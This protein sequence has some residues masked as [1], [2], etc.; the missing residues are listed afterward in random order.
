M[1]AAFKLILVKSYFDANDI[2]FKFPKLLKQFQAE[3][4][5]AYESRVKNYLLCMSEEQFSLAA[6]LVDPDDP[7]Q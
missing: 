6:E 1:A 5:P 7:K 2:G 3:A 4:D